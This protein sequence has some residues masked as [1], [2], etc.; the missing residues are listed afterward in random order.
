MP[1][2]GHASLLSAKARLPSV[3]FILYHPTSNSSHI[4]N[5][6]SLNHI[7]IV[8]LEDCASSSESQVFVM[9][10]MDID[11]YRDYQ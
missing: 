3:Q 2:Y 1:F 10:L 7:S 4:V 11:Q 8:D 9:E 5:V 6:S